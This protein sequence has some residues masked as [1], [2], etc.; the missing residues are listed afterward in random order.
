MATVLYEAWDHRWLGTATIDWTDASG[1]HSVDITSADIGTSGRSG[2]FSHLA[3]TA[4]DPKDRS[5]S[6][7]NL[8]FASFAAILQ[9]KMDAAT[10]NTITV[11]FNETNLA[12]VFTTDA[13]G[14]GMTLT[15]SDARNRMRRILGFSGDV[16]FNPNAV[17]IS[18]DARPFYLVR[19]AVDA[20][21]GFVP[22]TM[23][24]DEMKTRRAGSA[25]YTLGATRPARSSRWEHRHEPKAAVQRRFA[26]ADTLVGGASW[27][28]E[29]F[30]EHAA[31]Y[32][33]PCVVKDGT[34]SM[35]FYAPDGF[36]ESSVQYA[37]PDY[38]GNETVRIR[39]TSVAGY[40]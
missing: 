27:T 39:A 13:V 25:I 37:R 5:G 7:L 28:Y 24:G 16:A 30:L 17:Q 22:P 33:V 35:V 12:Y 23:I 10:A 9:S 14:F 6:T 3:L 19:A 40:L 18:S 26:V 4:V 31:K 38:D 21:S 32:G 1:A 36:G 15:G 29:D 34:E 2:L 8:G 20:K 11:T